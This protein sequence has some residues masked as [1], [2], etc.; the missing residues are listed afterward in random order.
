[1][2]YWIDPN[3]DDDTKKVIDLMNNMSCFSK[4][5]LFKSNQ[6]IVYEDKTI[7]TEYAIR[8]YPDGKKCLVSTDWKTGKSIVIKE[9]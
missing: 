8:E 4:E 7:S 5:E 1:M 9:L 6:Y 2:S 3:I